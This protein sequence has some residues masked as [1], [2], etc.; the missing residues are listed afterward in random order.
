MLKA[1]VKINISIHL[2]DE[3][4]QVDPAAS[5][6]LNL[7]IKY[8]LQVHHAGTIAV[9]DKAEAER[10]IE[11]INNHVRSTF[12]QMNVDPCVTGHTPDLALAF[13][14]DPEPVQ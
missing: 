2:E 6:I 9:A 7:A 5:A 1:H 3:S 8:P 14:G 13:G 4:V 12:K 11:M 10:V